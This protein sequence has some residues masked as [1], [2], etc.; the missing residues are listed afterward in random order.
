MK[1]HVFLWNN[2]LWTAILILTLLFLACLF[3]LKPFVFLTILNSLFLGAITAQGFVFGQYFIY[4]VVRRDE[5]SG[6]RQWILSAG[7]DKLAYLLVVTYSLTHRSSASIEVPIDW[8]LLLSRYVIILSSVMQVFAPDFGENFFYGA[9]RKFMIIGL[10]A[11]I[12]MATLVLLAKFSPALGLPL[13][14]EPL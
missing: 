14:I 2:Y 11:G 8:Q 1:T 5:Y 7:L 12:V 10:I 13:G 9:N 4:T 6:P 3:N